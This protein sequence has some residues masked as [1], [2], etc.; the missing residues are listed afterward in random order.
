MKRLAIIVVSLLLMIAAPAASA[1]SS[2]CTSYT[3]GCIPTTPTPHTG[4]LPFTGLDLALL[5]VGGGALLGL[6]LVIRKTSH[7]RPQ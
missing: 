5:V 2:T 7:H 6:G 4:T 3:Q 1:Q